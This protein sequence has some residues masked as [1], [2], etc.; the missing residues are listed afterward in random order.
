MLEVKNLNVIVDG[1]YNILK[2][3]S[4]SLNKGETLSIIGESGSGK[5]VLSKSILGLLKDHFEITKGTIN[6]QNSDLVTLSKKDKQ[7]ILGKDI[8]LVMQN[9]MT[10]LNPTLTI[11]YQIEEVI[12]VHNKYTKQ[13][14]YEKVLQLLEEVKLPNPKS[15]IKKYPH[16]LSGGMKQRVVIA[17][18]IAN[19]PKLLI[20]DEPTT[21]LDV[22]IQYK[23]I[24][25]LKELQKKYDMSLIMISHN[26]NLIKYL[27]GNILIMYGGELME[28]GKSEKVFKDPKH[29]YTKGLIKCL[30]TSS[31]EVLKNIEGQIIKLDE[32]GEG[33]PFYNRCE[34]RINLCLHK[35]NYVV[36]NESVVKCVKWY[37]R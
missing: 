32:K 27:Q 22:T 36:N 23:I 12:K 21:A 35:V 15:I 20:A 6:F 14:R 28:F 33:C 26:L 7:K 25:L 11:G 13:K 34:E 31:E 37:E 18:A 30:P 16:E 4:F 10:S 2:D 5:T 3:I 9:P 17:I 1:K 29:P 19:S 8:S 24:N